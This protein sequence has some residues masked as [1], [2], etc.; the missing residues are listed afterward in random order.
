LQ[1][2]FIKLKNATKTV[3]S[4]GN[5][6]LKLVSDLAALLTAKTQITVR[7]GRWRGSCRLGFPETGRTVPGSGTRSSRLSSCRRPAKTVAK[8]SLK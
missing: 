8:R 4:D 3:T 2:F 1:K 5:I 7:R 6:T